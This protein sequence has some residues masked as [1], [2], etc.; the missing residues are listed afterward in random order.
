MTKKTSKKQWKATAIILGIISI[1]LLII[2][3]NPNISV[4]KDSIT[5]KQAG[6]KITEYLNSRVGGGVVYESSEDLGELYEV[7]VSYQGQKEPTFIT[8]DGKYFIQRIVP[9]SQA[10]SQTQQT[11]QPPVVSV[12]DA[13][14]NYENSNSKGAEN[15]KVVILEYSSFSCG[16]CNRVRPTINQ[17][18]QT[19]PNDV[20]IIYKHFNRGGSDLLTAQAAE[21]AGDQD[22]FWEMH[23]MIFDSGP[24]GDLNQYAKNLGLN[25][26]EFD[27]CLESGKYESKVASDT[28]EARSLGMGGTP[29][30]LVNDKIVSGA[31][32][33]ENFKTIIDAELSG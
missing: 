4:S 22:K 2:I 23:D 21:C 7:T 1:I 10:T 19:Y 24:N 32:P 27:I 5:G 12:E 29:G 13:N 26:D 20:K 33:F 16:Y 9:M 15:A 30:F 18:L 31:Q 6:D 28:N 11:Q 25:T 8:K 3:F 17:I 14:I